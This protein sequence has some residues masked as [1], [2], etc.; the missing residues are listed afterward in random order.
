MDRVIPKQ[1]NWVVVLVSAFG[2]AV[3]TI[4]G[5][6]IVVCNGL[7]AGTLSALM[8]AGFLIFVHLPTFA[9][10]VG[11]LFLFGSTSYWLARLRMLQER[12][13][14]ITIALPVV[15]LSA[16]IAFARLSGGLECALH[17]WA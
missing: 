3:S 15:A 9:V 14:L 11:L 1:P 2:A 4:W 12:Q 8:R 13:E 6:E 16:G 7:V 17:P 10:G 5:Y